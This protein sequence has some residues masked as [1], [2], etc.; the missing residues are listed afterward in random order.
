M[1]RLLGTAPRGDWVRHYQSVGLLTISQK[2]ASM[3]LKDVASAW[4]LPPGRRM[5]EVSRGNGAAR[6]IRRLAL[7]C[8]AREGQ[9]DSL[10]RTGVNWTRLAFSKIDRPS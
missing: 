7:G 9:C 4:P 8:Q 3:L 5:F 10:K 6:L 1:N 2:I